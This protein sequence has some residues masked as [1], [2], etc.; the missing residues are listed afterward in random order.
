MI[1]AHANPA[2]VPTSAAPPLNLAQALA[3]AAMCCAPDGA[4]EL[5]PVAMLVPLYAQRE[6]L[7]LEA[8]YAREAGPLFEDMVATFAG[9]FS[10]SVYAA[11]L[12]AIA[13]AAEALDP[14]R[15]RERLQA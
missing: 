1:D 11:A 15:M 12:A 13:A 4:R 6:G 8:V 2:E 3:V 5:A 10:E 7:S 9:I 14:E